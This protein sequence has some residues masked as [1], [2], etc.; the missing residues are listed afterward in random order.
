MNLLVS[1]LRVPTIAKIALKA[2]K[3]T[4]FKP[5]EIPLETALEKQQKLLKKKFDRMMNTDIGKELGVRKG[6]E[7]QEL[8]VTDYGFYKPFF[9]KPSQGAFMYPLEQYARAKTSGTSGTEKWFMTPRIAMLKTFKETGLPLLLA[10]FHNGEKITLEYGDII[11]VNTGPAPYMSGS[12]ISMGIQKGDIPFFRV[13][14][15]LNLSYKEKLQYFIL[16]YENIAGAILSTHTLVS[17]IMPAIDNPIALKGLFITEAPIA[18]IYMDDIVRF[19]GVTPRTIYGSTETMICSVA[20]VQYPLGFFFDWR[21]GIFEFV[22]IEHETSGER[23]IP[24]SEVD[25]GGVYRLVFTS[26]DGELTRIDTKD[27]FTC[28]AKR[29]DVLGV[30]CPIF[31]IHSRLE[32]V[33]ILQNFPR[34]GEEE[35]IVALRDAKVPFYEFTARVEVEDALEYLALYIELIKDM[36]AEVLEKAVHKQLYEKNKDYRDLTDFYEYVPVK[37]HLLEKGTFNKYMEWKGGTFPR[38]AHINMSKD[39]FERL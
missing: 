38:V 12:I 21:R 5:L 17:Q 31:K 29:D 18:D 2:Y 13:V 8:P 20:S 7:L 22:P 26:L 33:I 10:I 23:C 16:N 36:K 6:V 19:A 35:I 14:P 27:A 4:A 11:Y 37:I 39:D 9:D 15:N 30:E 32:K 1:M 25:V 28:I 3:K 34:I 24:I